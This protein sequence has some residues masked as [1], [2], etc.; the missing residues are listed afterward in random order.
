MISEV[1]L[2]ITLMSFIVLI[3]A[4]LRAIGEIQDNDTPKRKGKN[5][6]RYLQKL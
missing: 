1:I 2:L 3:A 5:S 4:K 6:R